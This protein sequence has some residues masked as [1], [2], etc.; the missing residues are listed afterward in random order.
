MQLLINSSLLQKRIFALTTI[1]IC[2]INTFL[3]HFLASGL[4]R[5]A[6]KDKNTFYSKRKTHDHLRVTILAKQTSF[7]EFLRC[8]VN[9]YRKRSKIFV[10]LI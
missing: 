3:D 2:F 1:A 7:Y 9:E 5:T 4:D 6:I 8:L 10:L